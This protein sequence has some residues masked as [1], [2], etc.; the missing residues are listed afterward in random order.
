MYELQEQNIP[1]HTSPG[2]QYDRNGPEKDQERVRG[3]PFGGDDETS[4]P[5]CTTPSD[6]KVQEA[7]LEH[8]F[9]NIIYGYE[10]EVNAYSVIS[11]PTSATAVYDTVTD[12]EH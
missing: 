3:N 12:K 5:V 2:F 8:K 6:N 9:D 7:M 10:P 11:D 1:I 4:D